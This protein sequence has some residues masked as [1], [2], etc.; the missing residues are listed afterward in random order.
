M[1]TASC[2]PVTP[3]HHQEDTSGHPVQAPAPL[4]C[5]RGLLPGSV[6]PPQSP[7]PGGQGSLPSVC[8]A[9]PHSSPW[10]LPR[11]PRAEPS[12]TA[13]SVL[14]LKL[15]SDCFA[16]L[17]KPPWWLP[18]PVGSDTDSS[19]PRP[20]AL[21][22]PALC[23]SWALSGTW[24]GSQGFLPAP[25]AHGAVSHRA[26]PHPTPS[27]L[28]PPTKCHFSREASDSSNRPGHLVLALKHPRFPPQHQSHVKLGIQCLSPADSE[29][30]CRQSCP[31]IVHGGDPSASRGVGS[32][33]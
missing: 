3:Q 4:V 29:G 26:C 7:A 14:F 12:S 8:R 13:L 32:L 2:G 24:K 21:H 11:A 18:L 17:L 15:K 25:P 6:S 9:A 20:P 5:P 10:G 1:H 22:L 16:P 27:S 19:P 31:G 23:T 33:G 28:S 30:L